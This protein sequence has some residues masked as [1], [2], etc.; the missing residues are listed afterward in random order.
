MCLLRS[1]AGYTVKLIKGLLSKYAML[2]IL[3]N[4]AF[5]LILLVYCTKFGKLILGKIA[6]IVATRCHIL[7]LKCTKFDFGKGSAPHPAGGAYSVPQTLA[8]YK[9]AYFYRKERE[10]GREERKK[11]YFQ[12]EGRGGRKKEGRVSPPNLQT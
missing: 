11:T 9:G 2:I 7:N 4:L 12:G 3:K 10:E 6:K 5:A 1:P 8:G